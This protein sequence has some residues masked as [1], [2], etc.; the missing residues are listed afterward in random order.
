MKIKKWIVASSLVVGVVTASTAASTAALSSVD[1]V[2]VEHIIHDYLVN[3]PEV[4]LEA[5][6]SLQKKEQKTLQDHAKVA[7]EQQAKELFADTLTF[8]GNPKGSVTLVEFFDYQCIH[9]KKMEPVVA[10]LVKKNPEL[11]VIYKEFPIFGDSS[12]YASKAAIA[13]ANQGKYLAMQDALLKVEKHLDKSIVLAT[14]K[15]IGLNIDKLKSDIASKAVADVVE[16]NRKLAESLHLMGTPAFI[17]ATTPAGEFKKGSET[18]FI[19]GGASAETFQELITK[20]KG[21]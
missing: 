16:A 11:R 14:A 6:Q 18:T 5:S 10:E 17:V 12:V 2:Q 8:S 21:N 15:S 9:C 20:A 7:I 13:A 4:L 3:N 1:K 19:P